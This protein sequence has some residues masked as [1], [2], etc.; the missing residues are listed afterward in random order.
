LCLEAKEGPSALS[1]SVI[2]LEGHV[3]RPDQRATAPSVVGAG[4]PKKGWMAVEALGVVVMEE[5]VVAWL[6][7]SEESTSSNHCMS[8]ALR[9][10]LS[11]PTAQP[12]IRVVQSSQL[13]ATYISTYSLLIYILPPKEQ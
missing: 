2:L 6:I 13:L 10:L 7:G 3:A 12:D 11:G 5:V 4:P 9:S 1:G 8:L